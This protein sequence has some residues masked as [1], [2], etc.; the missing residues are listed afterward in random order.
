MLVKIFT[1]TAPGPS[2]KTSTFSLFELESSALELA[3]TLLPSVWPLGSAP[4]RGSFDA[5]L[6]SLEPFRRGA[7]SDN[8]CASVGSSGISSAKYRVTDI[9]NKRNTCIVGLISLHTLQSTLHKIISHA[10]PK[11]DLLALQ[12]VTKQLEISTAGAAAGFKRTYN[13]NQ[14]SGFQITTSFTAC[15]CH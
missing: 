15:S 4:L 3:G 6:S 9:Q 5:L 8:R 7:E 13:C 10:I 11:N 2:L 14:K 1:K 12:A